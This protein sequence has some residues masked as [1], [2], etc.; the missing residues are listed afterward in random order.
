MFRLREL[1]HRCPS[2]LPL[3]ALRPPPQVAGKYGPTAGATEEAACVQCPGGGTS[4][5]GST[6]L[7]DCSAT[8]TCTDLGCPNGQH[9]IEGDCDTCHKCPVSYYGIA[10]PTGGWYKDDRCVKCTEG[11]V[12]E[13]EG[14]ALEGLEVALDHW[15]SHK[16][17]AEVHVCPDE[18]TCEGGTETGDDSCIEG[19]IDALC[20]NCEEG[21]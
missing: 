7:D 20:S 5:A 9:Q 15:R 21:W 10:S 1:P 18:D 17:V 3:I 16:S 19:S 12:C 4:D 2:A 8:A 6:V 14:I 11:M 13:A